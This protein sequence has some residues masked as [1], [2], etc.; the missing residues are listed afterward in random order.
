MA[1]YVF[2]LPFDSVLTFGIFLLCSAIAFTYN[3]QA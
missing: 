3:E 1:I 2:G